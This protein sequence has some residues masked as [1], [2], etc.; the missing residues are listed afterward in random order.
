[1]LRYHCNEGLGGWRVLLVKGALE[2]GN[3][4]KQGIFGTR[5]DCRIVLP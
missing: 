4:Y 1:M 5:H 3:G 2:D